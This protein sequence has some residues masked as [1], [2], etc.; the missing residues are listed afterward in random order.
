[1]SGEETCTLTAPLPPRS[2]IH[3]DSPSERHNLP[4]LIPLWA[5]MINGVTVVWQSATVAFG[6]DCQRRE[7]ERER[8]EKKIHPRQTSRLRHV[9]RRFCSPLPPRI[10]AIL[11]G[12][13]PLCQVLTQ[14]AESNQKHAVIPDVLSD[15]IQLSQMRL[16]LFSA[17]H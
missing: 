17:P 13:R 6:F 3:A 1:M 8:E 11:K 15:F 4:N 9:K 2:P 16:K 10:F 12:M 5:F 14:P 7:M